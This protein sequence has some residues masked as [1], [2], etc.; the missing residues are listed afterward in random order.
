ME[1]RLNLHTPLANCNGNTLLLF[2]L[3]VKI[4]QYSKIFD[5][6]TPHINHMHNKAQPK[7]S[8]SGRIHAYERKSQIPCNLLRI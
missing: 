1:K 8:V 7:S 2:V 6:H 3:F 5:T 4:A